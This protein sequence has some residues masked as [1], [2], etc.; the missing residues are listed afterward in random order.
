[1]IGLIVRNR[2]TKENIF[3]H[4]TINTIQTHIIIEGYLSIRRITHCKIKVPINTKLFINRYTNVLLIHQHN[5]KHI[6][7]I[8]SFV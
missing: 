7:I 3:I 6:C 8:S 2:I 1:M 4:R 5:L